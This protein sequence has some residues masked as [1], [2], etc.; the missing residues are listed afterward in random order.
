VAKVGLAAAGVHLVDD[1]R[2][3]NVR[4]ELR[5]FPCQHRS[6]GGGGPID[7]IEDPVC[8]RHLVVGPANAFRLDQV[9]AVSQAR[10]IDQVQRHPVQVDLLPQRI[11]GRAGDRRDDGGFVTGEAVQQARLACVRLARDDDADALAKQGSLARRAGKVGERV[12]QPRET[13]PQGAVVEEV[14]VF[15]RKVD[16][17]FDMHAGRRDAFDQRVDLQRELSLQGPDRG[18]RGG[19]GRAVDEIGDGLCFDEVDLVVEEGATAEFARLGETGTEREGSLQQP[20]E[21]DR[22]PVAVQ[23]EEILASERGWARE[24]QR[25]AAVQ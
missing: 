4:G 9:R 25:E 18:P 17:R 16:G 2:D 14:D 20:V 15:L 6:R 23:L 22:A 11:A 21:D 24:E 7:D 3:G 12:Q 10:R 13:G 5:E 19:I 8:P 1:E